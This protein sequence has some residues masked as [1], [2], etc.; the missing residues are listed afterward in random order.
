MTADGC[1]AEV[2]K[3][4]VSSKAFF[5]IIYTTVLYKVVCNI[6]DALIMM[7]IF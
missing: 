2:V 3:A 1:K 6:Y 4:E 5:F 7:M